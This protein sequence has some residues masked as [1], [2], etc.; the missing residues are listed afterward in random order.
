MEISKS[1]KFAWNRIISMLL[2]AFCL[3]TMWMKWIDFNQGGKMVANA[4]NTVQ[5]YL[6]GYTILMQDE[7]E[8]VTK[9]VE[10]GGIS[11]AEGS[12]LLKSALSMVNLLEG[13]G[14]ASMAGAELQKIPET[15]KLVNGVYQ[16]LFWGTIAASIWAAVRRLQGKDG[17]DAKLYAAF[18]AGDFLFVLILCAQVRNELSDLAQAGML[19]DLVRPTIWA[20]LAPVFAMLSA[21]LWNEKTRDW[22]ED[23][24]VA[25]AGPKMDGL[26]QYA[27]AAAE[28]S[29]AVL[30]S[31]KR[32]AEDLVYEQ[33][34][35]KCPGCGAQVDA[36]Q[37][38]CSA[39]GERRPQVCR[40]PSCGALQ[41]PGA[42][43]CSS[44]GSK[45][46]GE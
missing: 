12:A 17:V 44:C 1:L 2:L 5:R 7:I 26:R 4:F 20:V 31:C 14:L 34:P 13:S 16:L 27:E 32:R 41:K 8:T 42:S 24:L 36:G 28:K 6:S 30:V 35:W 37:K 3:A 38:F 45:F 40:C 11:L 23:K 10:D 9:A 25:D 43:F 21:V 29:G 15:I 46:D 19:A 18:F 22:L 33:K 39:C